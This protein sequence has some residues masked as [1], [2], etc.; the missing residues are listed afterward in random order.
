MGFRL[1]FADGPR[2]S[3][4]FADDELGEFVGE[5]ETD[6]NGGVFDTGEP[7]TLVG[8]D[9]LVIGDAGGGRTC[10]LDMGLELDGE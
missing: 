8:I 7:G 2:R 4:I 6:D 3:R 10:I 5:S 1:N 9:R